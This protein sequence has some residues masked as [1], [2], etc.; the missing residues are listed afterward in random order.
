VNLV[1][2]FVAVFFISLFEATLQEKIALA[3]NIT[4]NTGKLGHAS[5]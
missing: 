1:T 3:S 5:Q 4:M 2:V